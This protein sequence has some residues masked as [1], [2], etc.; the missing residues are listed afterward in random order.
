MYIIIRTFYYLV[1]PTYQSKS[2]DL[3][4]VL[5][6]LKLL[7][8][9]AV[10]LKETNLEW[11]IKGYRDEFHKLLV[12]AFVAERLECT[13]TKDKFKTLPFTPGETACAALGKMVHSVVKT[14]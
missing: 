4:T 8:T 1:M 9:G 2:A 14:G 12:K 7:Q 11:H 3:I 10:P 6:R 13:T 5:E